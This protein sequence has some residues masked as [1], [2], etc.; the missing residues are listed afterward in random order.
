MVDPIVNPW[1]VAAIKPVI[2]EAGGCFTNWEGVVTSRSSNAV[3]S[4][5]I[6]H[7]R[8]LAMLR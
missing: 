3:G 4:N 7:Q 1:D 8:I 5:G 6:I 2:E